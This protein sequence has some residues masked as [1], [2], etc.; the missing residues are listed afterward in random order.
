VHDLA[1]NRELHVEASLRFQ[2]WFEQ[3]TAAGR[4]V[5]YEPPPYNPASTKVRCA[6]V[7]ARQKQQLKQT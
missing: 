5:T 1:A 4:Y 6:F 3:Q 7:R 2:K